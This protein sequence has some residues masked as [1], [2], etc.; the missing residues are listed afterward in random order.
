MADQII[1]LLSHLI[2]LH[3]SPLVFHSSNNL[4][5]RYIILFME[6]EQQEG[7]EFF[8]MFMIWNSLILLFKRVM[9]ISLLYN[10]G[11]LYLTLLWHL[12][13]VF[14]RPSHQLLQENFLLKLPLYIIR[15][16]F[17]ISYI[18]VLSIT[19]YTGIR[20]ISPFSPGMGI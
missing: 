18:K 10:A 20:I 5:F 9:L 6:E 12:L 3:S 19:L 17:H 11:F 4:H 16:E 15:W 1:F 8:F 13:G 14:R 2:L 7:G